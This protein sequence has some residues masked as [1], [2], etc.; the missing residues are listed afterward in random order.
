MRRDQAF[1][2]GAMAGALVVWLWGPKLEH[3]IDKEPRRVRTP[4]AGGIQA[5]EA[6]TT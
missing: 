3:R 6:T 5:V 4:A 1:L 2:L